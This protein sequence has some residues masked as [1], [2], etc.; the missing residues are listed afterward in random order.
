M[1]KLKIEEIIVEAKNFFEFYNKKVGEAIRSPERVLFINFNDL[2]GFSPQLS[3][4]L[5]DKPEESLS[6]LELALQ[7]KWPESNL[8]IRISDLPKDSYVKIRNIRSKNLSKFIWIE[9]IVRQASDVRPQVVSARFEC[10]SCGTIISVLQL[11]RKFKEPTRCSC[12]RK[13]FFKLVSKQMVDAQRIVLEESPDALIGGE[14]PRRMNVFLKEDLVEPKME[15]RTTPGS[16]VRVLGILN[17]VPVPLPTGG[18]TTRF[19]LAV[20]AN[21]VIPLEENYEDLKISEEDELQIKELSVDPAIFTKLTE[22]IAPSIYGHSEVKQSLVLQL[23]GGVKKQ[24]V[25]GT[26]TRGDIHVLL[27]GDPGVAKSVILK[28]ISKVAPKGRY[29]VGKSASGAGLTATV[30]RDEFLKGWSLEAGAMVLSHKGTVCIDEIE[31]MDEQDRSSMHEAMEQQSVTI[32]KANVQASLRAET[33]VLAAGNPKFGRFDPYQAI[34]QQVDIQPTLLNRFDVIF[35]LRDLPDKSKDEAIASHVLS[36]F[37]DAGSMGPIEPELFRKYIAYAKQ[38]VI[39]KLS[40]AAANEIRNFYVS[41]RNAPTQSDS[42]LKPIPITARQLEA[43]VRLSEASA[44]S[45]LSQVVEK[46]DA[47]RAINLMKFYLMQAGYDYESKTFDI[48]KIVSGVTSSKRAKINEV[49][50]AIFRLESRM[51]KMIPTEELEKEM[52]GKVTPL[53]LEEILNK[54]AASSDI[55]H[56]RSGYIQRLGS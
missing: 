5:L 54:L 52:E 41:L 20:E 55:F 24:K 48:D 18:V 25:D 10:P 40:D 26:V 43:L 19:D 3:E 22:S 35:M 42:P 56:P 47:I 45:R 29:V 32:S 7:E 2:S 15:E 31:K 51:G 4:Y 50:E 1:D 8:K 16:K 28:F 53:E 21:N 37:Q 12:G 38:R 13:G 34:A 6:T 9:G 11:D 33:T 44:K 23:F 46:E 27:V 30:V 49:R 17:E 36:E 14:Q 39:P